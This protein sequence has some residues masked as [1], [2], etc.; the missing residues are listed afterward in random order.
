MFNNSFDF[1]IK[2]QPA[3]LHE[4][5]LHDSLWIWFFMVHSY[6]WT[7]TNVHGME[8]CTLLIKWLLHHYWYAFLL[9][10]AVRLHIFKKN[11]FS[12]F[13]LETKSVIREKCYILFLW[14]KPK[15]CSSMKT[16]FDREH[17]NAL[18]RLLIEQY[19]HELLL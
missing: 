19:F 15:F 10:Q 16:F 1:N 7:R 5:F 17:F 6:Q 13:H 4:S 14:W 9:V 12:R 18:N 11:I 2:H 8:K 3:V